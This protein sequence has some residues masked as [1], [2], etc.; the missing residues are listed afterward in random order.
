M[1]TYNVHFDGITAHFPTLP[2]ASKFAQFYF[3]QTGA[4][5]GIEA[6]TTKARTPRAAVDLPERA[7]LDRQYAERII[8]S[9]DDYFAACK[10]IGLRDDLRFLIRV[11]GS[12]MPANLMT[13]ARALLS[14]LEVRA[15]K[16][17]HCRRHHR[18]AIRADRVS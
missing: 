3:E 12:R 14:E 11:A 2:M 8:G 18:M 1:A 16:P 10:R 6:G 7:D 15:S 17:G 13:E 9:K 4:I 5:L